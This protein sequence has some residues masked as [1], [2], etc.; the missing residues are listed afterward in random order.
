MN[1]NANTDG[2]NGYRTPPGASDTFRCSGRIHCMCK[3]CLPGIFLLFAIFIIIAGC[4]QPSLKQPTVTVSNITLS[5]VTL[6]T[7]TV[8]TTVIVDNPNPEGADLN[9]VAFDIWY[10]DDTIH[11]LGHGE[12]K[13]LTIRENGNTTVTIPVQIGNVQALQAVGSLVRNGNITL[14]VNG[15][16]FVDLKVTSYEL[17]FTQHRVI[18]ASEFTGLIPEIP[19]GGRTINVTEGLD[20]ARGLLDA[21]TG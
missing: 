17:P 6:N 2:E 7:M 15:S 18:M 14:M 21:L 11:Y 19:V 9:R 20:Q 10:I 5:D 13:A 1:D 12:Q 4:T 16:A 8:N 3:Y